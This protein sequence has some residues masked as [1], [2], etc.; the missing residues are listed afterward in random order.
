MP[1]ESEP[2]RQPA[3]KDLEQ[4]LGGAWD[5]HRRQFVVERRLAAEAVWGRESIGRTA[6]QVSRSGH[7]A[8]LLAGKSRQV[9][10]PFFFFD[11]ETTGLNGGAGTYAF[12][13]GYG[14]FA[15]DGAFVTRQH[16]LARHGLE[17]GMLT[18]I[19]DEL[20]A[21]GSLVSF[22]GRSFDAPLLENRYLLHRLEWSA[23]GL[24]HLDVLHS[25]RRFWGRRHECSLTTL[26]RQILGARRGGDVPGAEIP[27]R[28]FHFVRTGDPRP[29]T[30]VFEHNRR[31][32]VTLAVLTGW[33]L[34]LVANGPSA[35]RDGWEALALGQLY[36]GAG[37]SGEAEAAF[38]HAAGDHRDS[39]ASRLEALHS[40]AVL[41][42]RQRRFDESVDC[43]RRLLAVPA[44]P[45]HLECEANEALAVHHEHR[46]GDLAAARTFA[47]KGLE[48]VAGPREVVRGDAFRH[49]LA[50]LE[51]KM[52]RVSGRP[53]FPSWPSPPSCG[54]PTSGRQT[55][56]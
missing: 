23:A 6:S 43:W 50:R 5:A 35:A 36:D 10:P 46:V 31:D 34:G 51:R 53:L 12:L 54:C 37:M 9:S 25:A 29:L 39:A 38:R 45:P 1:R 20:A 8:P 27:S 40:L 13:V 18:R 7:L 19:A 48:K 11:L 41:L 22:N 4:V 21:A 56:S 16:L 24:A 15:D 2:D 30:A 3:T 42:R 17:A 33:M 26:E 49:R 32:L 52:T 47:L 14:W 28:Y 55:S 44:C